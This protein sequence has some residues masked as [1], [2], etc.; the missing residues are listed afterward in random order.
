MVLA[1]PGNNCETET[2]RA[3]AKAGF[4]AHIVRWNEDPTLLESADGIV[5][6][7]GFSFEDR[8]R[9]GVIAAKNKVADTVRSLAKAGKPILGICNGAQ[10]LVEMGLVPGFHWGKVEMALA[11]NR[12][13]KKGKILGSGFFHDFVFLKKSGECAFTHFDRI[14]KMPIAHGEGR[15]VADPET[16]D[17]LEKN[18]QIVLKYCDQNGEIHPDFPIN[19]NGSFS[20]SAA[21]CN[22]E[23]NVM[24]IMP[25]PER[26]SEGSIIFDS[27]RDFFEGKTK[28]PTGGYFPEKIPSVT[29][30][31][32]KDF[33]LEIFVRL[34]ITD[35]TEATIEKTAQE[36]LG[37]ENL[38]I[39]RRVWWGIETAEDPY[40][41][42]KKL[43]GSDE[44]LNP[45]KESAFVK[46]GTEFFSVGNKKLEKIEGFSMPFGIF[47]G[48][49]DDILGKEKSEILE[50]HGGISVGISSGIFWEMSEKRDIQEIAKTH[51]FA[52]PVS[53]ILFSES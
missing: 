40:E 2:A 46:I 15:F 53:G 44:F 38:N 29:I 24:A 6:P 13:V 19:P 1:F 25:H 31:S 10:I 36:L 35:T 18:G 51:L 47:S 23:G 45:A 5:I 49:K 41:I 9:S 21:I 39:T 37:C 27:L 26:S 22:P 17:A 28:K 43:L 50:K 30:T 12:R 20:N 34:K 33:A 48:E 4:D 16:Q 3:V 7:G 52:N 8:G 42:A 32:K 14:I 11:R